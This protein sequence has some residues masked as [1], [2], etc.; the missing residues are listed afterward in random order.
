MLSFEAKPLPWQ[1]SQWQQLMSQ[2]Q[3]QKLAH[4]YLLHG[5]PGVGKLH[6]AQ[7]F[8]QLLLCLQPNVNTAAP[9]QQCKSCLLFNAGFH[10]DMLQIAPEGT[11]KPIKVDQIRQLIDFAAKTAQQGGYRVIIIDPA[12]AMNINASNALLKCLEEPGSNTILLLLSEQTS[13]LLATI[14]SR[15][16]V[17]AFPL[18]GLALAKDWLLQQS[19]PDN[20]LGKLLVAAH[21]Q[22][23]TALTFHKEQRLK[24]RQAL[25]ACLAAITKGQKTPVAAAQE[26]LDEDLLC[27][28]DWLVDWLAEMIKWA[29]AKDATFIKNQDMLKMLSYVSTK[30]GVTRLYGY[31]MWLS[32]QRQRLLG[33]ANQNKQLMLE[34]LFIGWLHLTIH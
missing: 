6:F 17:L 13:A 16:Q 20:D 14:K 1:L 21:Y 22:P 30:A 34:N 27:L 7:L 4:A 11:G 19:L 8:G 25:Q 28:F 32:E 33:A 24:Q 23:L 9:C 12:D 3:Q 15:C 26:W 29:M 18:P 2:R 10:P 31:Y 5:M